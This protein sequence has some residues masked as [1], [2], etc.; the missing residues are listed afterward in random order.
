MR[1]IRLTVRHNPDDPADD[2]KQVARLRRDLWA[3]SPVEVDPD[4]P[5]CATQRDAHRDAYFE[6]A[7][8]FPDEVQRVLQ[9]YGHEPRATL[10]DLGE[11]GLVCGNCG[12]FAGYVTEC[13]NCH[14]R[15]IDPCPHCGRKVARERY[16][17]V[18]GDLFVCPEC[19]G[20]VRLQ[21]NPDLC[22]A[23]GSFNQP[24]VLIQD[25]R[26]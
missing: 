14:H 20:R 6:F 9:E 17:P 1:R 4:N 10:E 16:Q 15:D 5:F 21:I 24:M 13:P 19:R 11:I 22:N 25:A 2:L 8:E 23:D 26:A 7:T 12:F 18:S 3:H